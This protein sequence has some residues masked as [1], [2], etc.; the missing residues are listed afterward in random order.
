M[1]GAAD[2]REV[3]GARRVPAV[4]AWR[5]HK[6]A[7]LRCAQAGLGVHVDTPQRPA[8]CGQDWR[9]EKSVLQCDG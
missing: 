3:G 4:R 2:G 8:L 1:E 9:E 5:Q 6:R 7:Q